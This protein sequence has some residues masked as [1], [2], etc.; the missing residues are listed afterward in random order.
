[1]PIHRNGISINKAGK[2]VTKKHS[3]M[4]RLQ[5]ALKKRKK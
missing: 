3:G 2:K 1:M 5:K 4:S